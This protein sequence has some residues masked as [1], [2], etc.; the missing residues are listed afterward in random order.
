MSMHCAQNFPARKQV[1]EGRRGEGEEEGGGGEAEDGV[2]MGAQKSDLDV[3]VP[4][5]TGDDVY[6]QLLAHHLLNVS[7]QRELRWQWLVGC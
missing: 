7:P 5:G 4:A 1:K 3:E 2:G 6:L